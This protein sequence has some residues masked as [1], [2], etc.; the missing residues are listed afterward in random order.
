MKGV[1]FTKEII[2]KKETKERSRLG[3]KKAQL[4]TREGEKVAPPTATRGVGIMKGGVEK[5]PHSWEQGR[6]GRVKERRS[7][8]RW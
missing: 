3:G 2:S 8:V 1:F 4:G 6:A 5:K 7:R